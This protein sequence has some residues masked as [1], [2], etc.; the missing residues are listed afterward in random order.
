MGRKAL[1]TRSFFEINQETAEITV[2][3]VEEIQ[4]ICEVIAIGIEAIIMPMG[5]DAF[6][7][8]VHREH[9]AEDEKKPHFWAQVEWTQFGK[10]VA[11]TNSIY[12]SNHQAD[13]TNVNSYA[14]LLV[15]ALITRKENAA[16]VVA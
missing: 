5:N 6:L 14:Q 7:W 16:L 4:R 9:P 1:S 15:R 8:K 11:V 13:P 10:V 2:A 12:I 3:H